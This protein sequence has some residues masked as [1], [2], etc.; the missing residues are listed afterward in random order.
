MVGGPQI[1]SAYRKSANLGIFPDYGSFA[2]VAIC[3]F[4]IS[5]PIFCGPK[6]SANP[7]EIIFF[8]TNI[9]LKGSESNLYQ[10]N[11]TEQVCAQIY[12]SSDFLINHYL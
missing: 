2:N 6:F 11:Y 3:G 4:V 7:Q 9:G 1:F 10:E 5:G 12:S 8:H